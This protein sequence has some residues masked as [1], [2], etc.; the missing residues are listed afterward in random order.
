MKKL[1]L[2]FL[3]TPALYGM[4]EEEKEEALKKSFTSIK[5]MMEARQTDGA[6]RLMGGNCDKVIKECKEGNL[7]SCVI[8]RKYYANSEKRKSAE[9][10]EEA[11]IIHA[12]VKEQESRCTEEGKCRKVVAALEGLL[13][14]EMAV[15]SRLNNGRQLEK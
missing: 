8:V 7:D 4:N 1:I 12:V 15:I 11:A 14:H 6:S 5:L 13:P 10:L 2:F 9:C 3:I